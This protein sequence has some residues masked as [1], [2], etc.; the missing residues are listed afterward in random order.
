MNRI[1]LF[2]WLSV[3]SIQLYSQNIILEKPRVDERIELLSIVFRLAGAEEYS[4][5]FFKRYTDRIEQHFL[6]Y[7]E[8]EIIK[9][10]QELRR[11]NGVSYDAVMSMAIHLNSHL[12]PV[13]PLNDTIPDM[14]WGKENAKKFVR[15][16]KKFYR[17]SNCKEFFK[18][19]EELYNQTS[20][21]F[22]PVYKEL[23]LHWYK[24]FYGKEPD[25]NSSL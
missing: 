19:N 7:K 17:E 13:V 11:T 12:N 22:Y 18:A 21:S 9:F 20:E 4:S 8:H 15:L 6:P 23:D 5:T 24:S 14:R 3:Y 25:E 16:L 1:I 2:L 10:V